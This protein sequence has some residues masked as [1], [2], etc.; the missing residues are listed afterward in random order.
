MSE[1]AIVRYRLDPKRPRRL[2]ALERAR[3]DRLSARRAEA[4]AKA[5]PDN[6]PLTD[7]Q[8]G[9]LRLASMIRSLRDRLALSQT[10]FAARFR[11]P[12][13]S[14]RDWEYGR[15]QPDAATRAYLTVI[16]RKPRMVEK[17]LRAA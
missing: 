12:V 8:L 7:D 5:D 15:R 4:A 2:T 14:L 13:G 6:P 1:K 16:A 10:A 11:I 9:R 3:L 17:A